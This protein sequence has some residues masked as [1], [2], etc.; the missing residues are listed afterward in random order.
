MRRRPRQ[1][2]RADLRLPRADQ[3]VLLQAAA[4]ARRVVLGR[5]VPRF[6]ITLIPQ[7][8]Q[9]TCGMSS[10]RHFL[11]ALGRRLRL[12][13]IVL[14]PVVAGLRHRL[15]LHS[16]LVLP[17][18]PGLLVRAATVLRP[19]Q[20][21][22]PAVFRPVP[23]AQVV[24]LPAVVLHRVPAGRRRVRVRAALLPRLAAVPPHVRPRVPADPRVRA[25]RR[26]VGVVQVLLHVKV[27]RVL[28]V[29]RVAH[30]GVLLRLLAGLLLRLLRASVAP[31]VL[32]AALRLILNPSANLRSD[33]LL[34]TIQQGHFRNGGLYSR[35][36][37]R[38]R[39]VV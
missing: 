20:A 27:P 31:Q 10:L 16:L 22:H 15:L 9:Q 1:A 33:G 7:H 36:K 23:A 25:R 34:K 38:S 29:R 19:D 39:L 18:A 2:V 30:V 3:A 26:P 17:V 12:A 35:C 14:L 37:L 5:A 28:L 24:L 21:V 11:P 32:R 13:A 4:A 6:P 8:C